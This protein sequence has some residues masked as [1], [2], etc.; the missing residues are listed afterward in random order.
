GLWALGDLVLSARDSRLHK[1]KLYGYMVVGALPPLLFLLYENGQLTGDWLRLAQDL[2]GT[3]DRPGFGP[4]H[5]DALGHTPALGV[6]NA[7]VYLRT[8]AT[9]FDGWPAPLAL[10]PVLLGLFA[11]VGEK[12]RKRLALD[13]L[14]WLCALG[15]FGAYFAWWSST[16]IF[17]PRYWYEA[18]PFLLLMAGRGLDLLGRLAGRG[19]GDALTSRLRLA[20]PATLFSV[21]TLYNLSQTLPYQ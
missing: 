21:L 17:G 18:M 13:A 10:T 11:W 8:L 4:G 15:L 16:T 3:Y 5:G 2:V 12:D 19:F 14:L 7:L 6:Y 9:V 1:L 20:V